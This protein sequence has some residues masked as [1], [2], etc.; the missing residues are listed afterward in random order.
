MDNRLKKMKSN[1]GSFPSLT[2]TETHRKEVLNRIKAEETQ[3]ELLLA[4]LQLLSKKRTGYELMDLIRARGF[5]NFEQKEGFLYSLL[6]RLEQKGFIEGIWN[7]DGVKYY[8]LDRKGKKLLRKIEAR[9][10]S[11]QKVADLLEWVSWN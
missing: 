6:H 4:I 8:G 2:F 5:R 9:K 10:Y 11:T 3:H 7:D 1:K